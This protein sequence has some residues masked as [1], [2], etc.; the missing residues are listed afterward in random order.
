MRLQRN[1]AKFDLY[2]GSKI[3]I[4]LLTTAICILHTGINSSSIIM[5]LWS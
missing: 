3:T 5:W 2:L 1:D 4:I